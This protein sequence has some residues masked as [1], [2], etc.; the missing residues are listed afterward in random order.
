MQVDA[1]HKLEQ[2]T[3]KRMSKYELGNVY[4]DHDRSVAWA[5]NGRALAVVPI[6]N[7]D[8]VTGITPIPADVYEDARKGKPSKH[9][10]VTIFRENNEKLRY[11][12]KT[13]ETSTAVPPIEKGKI[14]PVYET[15]PKSKSKVCMVIDLRLL[16]QVAAALGAKSNSITI[17]IPE[18]SA[19]QEGDTFLVNGPIRIR[20]AVDSHEAL[21]VMMPCSALQPYESIIDAEYLPNWLTKHDKGAEVRN[22]PD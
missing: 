6:D 4:V 3:N 8:G 11:L 20:A 10:Q 18:T 7:D 13:G 16:N 1:K 12:T 21:G 14:P 19:Y 22:D 5:T 15:I 2:L 17:I 9:G